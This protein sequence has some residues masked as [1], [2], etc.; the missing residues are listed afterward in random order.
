M[1]GSKCFIDTNVWLYAFIRSD[2]AGK[3]VAAKGLVETVKIVTS[4]QVINE[5]CVNLLKKTDLKEP[6]IAGLIS[7]FYN[8]YEI[9]E[10][11]QHLLERASDLRSAS[12]FSYWDSLIVAAALLSEAK[13]L[14]TEDM[15]DGLIVDKTLKIVNPFKG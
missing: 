5:L 10:S 13:I 4:F 12:N 2:D 8:R 1:P 6:D 7:S 3:H 9:V 15:H 14:Y 11:G